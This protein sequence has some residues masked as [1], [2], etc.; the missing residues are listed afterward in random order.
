M[1][2][3]ED[4][5]SARQALSQ[6]SKRYIAVPPFAS[7]SRNTDE[8]ASNTPYEIPAGVPTLSSEDFTWYSSSRSQQATA[9]YVAGRGQQATAP[10]TPSPASAQRP[11]APR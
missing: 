8:T 4:K 6:T 3:I 10:S 5:N 9:P 2:P 7:L 1:E 11:P